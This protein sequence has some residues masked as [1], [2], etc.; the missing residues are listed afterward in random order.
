[1]QLPQL[2]QRKSDAHKGDFGR[3][4]LIGGSQGMAGAIA[5]SGMAAVRSGA[6]LV[7]L[8]V[9]GCCLET[10]ASFDPTYMTMP[11]PHDTAGR[12]TGDANQILDP[13]LSRVD[14]VG[15]GPGLSLS[16]G[17][18]QVVQH[19]F[20]VYDGPMVVDADAI[21]VIA[22]GSLQ[23]KTHDRPRV[24][25]PHIGEFRR[26][27]CGV[28]ESLPETSASVAHCRE[29]VGTFAAK[30]GVVIVLKGSQTI[31]TDGVRQFKNDTGNAGMAS[32]GSGDVLTGV[33]TAL[34]GQG[35]QPIDAS[36]LGAHVHGLAGDLARAKFGEIGMS[37]CD[38]KDCLPA[39]WLQLS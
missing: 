34:L 25:T 5:L 24:L 7:T 13:L 31:V 9:P 1:M 11:L 10:V 23:A 22:E 26:L 4:L 38:T 2:P 15:I 20:E 3:V 35:M 19:V 12:V 8:A 6:G 30:Y 14:S 29:V 36:A 18:R 39:A 32:G 27:L 17:V 21:N 28:G 33:I 37:A 16:P